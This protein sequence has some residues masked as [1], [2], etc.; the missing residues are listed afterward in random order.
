VLSTG[1]PAAADAIVGRV[2]DRLERTLRVPRIDVVPLS[3]AALPLR[4]R[5]IRDGTLIVSRD[6]ARL[7]RFI[8]GRRC[9]TSMSRRSGSRRS[10]SN[11]PRFLRI[12]ADPEIIA[13]AKVESASIRATCDRSLR[14]PK[15]IL[16]AT[17][18]GNMRCCMRCNWR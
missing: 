3:R 17:A 4:Y 8:V 2:A 5:V 12:V 18:S 13:I 16:S 9:T 15:P 1:S 14:S 11:G 7:E 10:A 6:A